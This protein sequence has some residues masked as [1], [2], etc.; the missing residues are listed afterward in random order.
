MC[1]AQAAAHEWRRKYQAAV[2]AAAVL[3]PSAAGAGAA[4]GGPQRA[5]APRQLACLQD[6][7]AGSREQGGAHGL[8]HAERGR[9]AELLAA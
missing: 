3:S 8:A 9:Q 7:D 4:R 1:G 6:A 5:L 2:E